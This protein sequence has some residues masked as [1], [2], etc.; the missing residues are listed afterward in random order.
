MPLVKSNHSQP[1]P[2][3]THVW[4][5]ER[6]TE[7]GER[8]SK[9]GHSSPTWGPSKKVAQRGKEQCSHFVS[10]S[11]TA[12]KTGGSKARRK[13]YSKSQ[14]QWH[15]CHAELMEGQANAAAAVRAGQRQWNA[16]FWEHLWHVLWKHRKWSREGDETF[17]KGVEFYV[18]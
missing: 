4:N 3:W 9:W 17:L 18:I 2:C 7:N 1:S 11:Y 16:L 13:V 6:T 5:G 10:V 15:L 8:W 14:L 12:L